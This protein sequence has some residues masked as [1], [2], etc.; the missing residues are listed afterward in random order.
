M[1]QE[2]VVIDDDEAFRYSIQ[3]RARKSDWK[4]IGFE[5]EE[6]AIDYLKNS[7]PEML[8]VDIRMPRLEGH[9]VLELIFKNQQSMRADIVVTSSLKPPEEIWQNY[10]AYNPKFI[11]KSDITNFLKQYFDDKTP[12]K[13]DS[14]T[15]K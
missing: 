2:L 14:A 7:Q 4:V 11:L 10:Q 15:S 8:V 6:E 5:Q 12:K 1:P 13:N 3:R 9:E